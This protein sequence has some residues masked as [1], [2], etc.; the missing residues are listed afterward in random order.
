MKNSRQ[1]WLTF[2]RILL[3]LFIF[4]T[5]IY[6]QTENSNTYLSEKTILTEEKI[7]EFEEDVKNGEYIDIKNYTEEKYVDTSNPVSNLGYNLGEGISEF[8]GVKV[9]D[10]FK[11]ISKFIS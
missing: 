1:A 9:V 2:R 4:Y 8:F 10:F 11:F 5:I 7:K 3:I 6:F